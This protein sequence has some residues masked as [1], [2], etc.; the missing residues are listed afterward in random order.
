MNY[1]WLHCLIYAPIIVIFKSLYVIIIINNLLFACAGLLLLNV[2]QN[3]IDNTSRLI[4]FGFVLFFPPFFYITNQI[5]SEPLF[6]FLLAVVITRRVRLSKNKKFTF[7][8][9]LAAIAL[10]LTRGFGL[11]IL[12]GYIVVCLFK[13]EYRS[14]VIMG[15]CGIMS[16]VINN[17]V[18]ANTPDPALTTIT[19]PPPLIHSVYFSNT[20]NGN[21]DNDFF[22]AYPEKAEQDT[23]FHAYQNG[24][25]SSRELLVELVRQNITSPKKFFE[26]SFNK[27]SAYFLN[28]IPDSWNYLGAPT[29]PMVRKILWGIQNSVILAALAFGWKKLPE[30]YG[31]YYT[32][33]FFISFV[34]HFLALRRYR[35]FQPL[36]VLGIPAIAITIQHF[37]QRGTT[38]FF[39]KQNALT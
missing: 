3:I 21:G 5:L 8:D 26:H 7:A 34:V 36:L 19:A 38:A 2:L 13:K 24:K 23:F 31:T 11:F 22:L 28:I 25:Y 6:I 9:I 39:E 15:V 16:I 27:V 30:R 33:L 14:A 20:T 1:Q 29:Q 12:A 32:V 17:A 10:S 18:G 4:A 37:I 35:Y